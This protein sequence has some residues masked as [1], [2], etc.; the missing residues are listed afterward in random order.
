MK[1]TII[2]AG[3]VG[4]S[5]GKLALE[6]GHDVL[7][8]DRP[9]TVPAR[10]AELQDA[11]GDRVAQAEVGEATKQADV[12]ILSGYLSTL[13][14][15]PADALDGKITL[16]VMNYYP[17]RDGDIPEL[18]GDTL[19]S[20]EWVGRQFRGARLVKGF[21]TV[22]PETMVNK[23]RRGGDIKERLVMWLAGDNAEAKKAVADLTLELG[24][25]PVDAGTLAASR[26]FLARGSSI[27][28]LWLS[29]SGVEYQVGHESTATQY[30]DTSQITTLVLP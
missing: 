15:I 25:A 26:T 6:A 24:F 7:L 10:L 29:V 12:V 21:N 27:Y 18:K 3:N 8:V 2:G 23:S 19:S 9:G 28:G 22:T 1:I 11:Y 14:E 16:D 20:T 17:E 4:S 13:D 30:L 5:M